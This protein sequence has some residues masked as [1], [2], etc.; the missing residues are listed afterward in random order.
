MKNKLVIALVLSLILVFEC[1]QPMAVV[2]ANN[3]TPKTDGTDEDKEV[4]SNSL[5]IETSNIEELKKDNS[6]ENVTEVAEGVFVVDYASENI[7]KEKYES[8]LKN[9]F[10]DEVFEDVELSVLETELS[11]TSV[12]KKFISWGVE[13]TGMDHYTDYL[14][15]IQSMKHQLQRKVL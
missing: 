1:I 3:T 14:N 8:L 9:N 15:Y 4:L 5:I 7:A 2:K 13:S 10:I 11:S 12:N 6:V